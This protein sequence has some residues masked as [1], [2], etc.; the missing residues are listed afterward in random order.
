ME[1]KV[2]SLWTSKRFYIV[3]LLFFNIIINYIDRVSVGVAAPV[4]SKEFGWDPAQMGW[5]FGA[6]GWAYVLC[7]IPSGWLADRLGTR[8]V[9]MLAITVWSMAV[10][11]T[12]AVF[13]FGSMVA[14]RMALGAGEA[15]SYPNA[16]KVIRNWVPAKERG[17]ATAIW[18]N[19][20]F[21]GP[22]IAAPFIA[23]LIINF[24]WRW[25]FLI[26][27]SLGIIWLVFWVKWY[28][29]PEQCEWLSEEEKQ[30]II[31]NRDGEA[32][33]DRVVNQPLKIR[34]VIGQ[35]LCQKTYWGLA[36]ALGTVAYS[37]Y[38]LLMWLPTYLTQ[39]RG[40]TL[41]DASLYSSVPFIVSAILGIMIGRL[42]DRLL[43]PENIR[44]GKRKQMLITFILMAS[45]ILL[46]NVVNNEWVVLAILSIALASLS[47]GLTLTFALVN[48]LVIEP[49]M[50]AT[51]LGMV[52]FCSNTCGMLSSIITGYIVK[53]SGFN[54][55]FYVAG[56]L[57]IV[58][59]VISYTF[60]GQP[61]VYQSSEPHNADVAQ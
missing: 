48:D 55:A 26:L 57:L 27:G 37:H 14:A 46:T 3:L 31:A 52:L 28:R 51:V 58:G 50:A 40:M 59:A 15:A 1:K 16:G 6:F 41:M 60:V 23:W 36:L 25:S 34:S 61:I 13:N 4:M 56:A 8:K 53:A 17:V 38:L 12:G 33:Q 44:R 19:G 5:I 45:I 32:S 42:S 9:S 35:V 43:T 30:Y 2:L 21:V 18:N 22:A 7:L 10:A 11:S 54:T 39:A 47:T 24:G 20:S 29:E 49:R